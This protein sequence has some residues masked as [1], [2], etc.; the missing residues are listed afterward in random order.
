MK[1]LVKLL[2]EFI[3]WRWA[4]AVALLTASTLYVIVVVGVVPSEIG[5]PVANAKFV[6]R[7]LSA[8]TSLNET[9]TNTYT[10]TTAETRTISTPP[11]Q[12]AMRRLPAADFGRRGFSPPLD[13]PEPPPAAAAPTTPT[14]IATP[15]RGTFTGIFNRIQGALRPGAPATQMLNQAAQNAAQPAAAAPGA[16]AAVPPPQPLGNAA[17]PPA[18]GTPPPA[19]PGNGAPPAAAPPPEGAP[20]GAQP[21]APAAPEAP[22]QE[23]APAP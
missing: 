5:V 14:Q 7:D 8:G 15:G 4:P 18:E 3:A 17:P 13:R 9:S 22:A 1:A 6:P 12:A 2:L 10:A 20:P 23:P 11:P 21:D 16:P 19:P